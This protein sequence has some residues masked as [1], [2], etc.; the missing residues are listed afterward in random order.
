MLLQSWFLGVSCSDLL[1]KGV[2][3]VVCERLLSRRLWI[4]PFPKVGESTARA[5]F[6]A[7]CR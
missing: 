3:G 4:P 5:A 1:W 7:G 6:I 2:I